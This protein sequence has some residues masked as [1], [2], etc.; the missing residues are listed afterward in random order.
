M[1]IFTEPV[2]IG[3]LI[4]LV[5]LAIIAPALKKWYFDVQTRLQVDSASDPGK[6]WLS[7]T[8]SEPA[9]WLPR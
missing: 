4:G 3:S 8:A 9:A 2:I 5:A 7:T 1:S 6:G